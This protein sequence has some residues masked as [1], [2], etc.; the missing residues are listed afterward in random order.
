M[1]GPCWATSSSLHTHL[2]L[3]I[4]VPRVIY[5]V[6]IQ[7]IHAVES[8]GWGVGDGRDTGGLRTQGDGPVAFGTCL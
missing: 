1:A 5:C 3:D 6:F 2:G 8:G 7:G 4:V